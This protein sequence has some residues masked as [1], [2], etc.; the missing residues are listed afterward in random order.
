MKSL[1]YRTNNL[2]KK[3]IWSSVT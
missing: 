1:W 3:E 2:P